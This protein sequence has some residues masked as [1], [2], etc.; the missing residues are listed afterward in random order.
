MTDD[1]RGWR[2]P[3]DEDDER[4]PVANQLA[5]MAVEALREPIARN[6][7]RVVKLGSE[8]KIR[9]VDTVLGRKG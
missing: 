9:L 4:S 8:L 1:E 3:R 5:D 6:I 7:D 2:P